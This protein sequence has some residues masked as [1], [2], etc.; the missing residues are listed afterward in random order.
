MNIKHE[1]EVL[2]PQGQ[3]YPRTVG[4]KRERGDQRKDTREWSRGRWR[5]RVYIILRSD[6][7]DKIGGKR[8]D[9]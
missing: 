2:R 7:R 4:P 5:E 9:A 6:R 1:D 3:K 8:I